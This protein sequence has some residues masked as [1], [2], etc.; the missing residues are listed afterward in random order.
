MATY[1]LTRTEK[2]FLVEESTYATEVVSRPIGT[3]AMPFINLVVKPAQ[4]MLLRK[5]KIGTRTMPRPIA[6][7]NISLEVDIE[8]YLIPSGTR[9]TAPMCHSLLKNILG[10]TPVTINTTVESG[11]T[12]SLVNVVDATGI[13]AGT[14]LFWGTEGRPVLSINTKAV[15]M[16][17]P[18]SSAPGVG[19]TIKGINYPLADSLAS[20]LAVYGY[21][22]NLDQGAL[23]CVFGK[24]AISF[25]DELLHIKASGVGSLETVA[26]GVTSAP[27][28]AFVG[29][30]ISRSF[31]QVY[32]GTTAAQL[33]DLSI[34]VEN[35][36][37]PR[38]YA[39]GTQY[40]SG[41][42]RGDRRI[43]DS[44]K[45]Y[46]TDTYNAFY[47]LAKARTPQGLFVQIGT[48]SGYMVA[49]YMPN[50]I[51]Q[52]PDLD[53]SKEEA[54]LSFASNPAYGAGGDEFYMAIG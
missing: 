9:N 14:I 16:A 33:I 8:S 23:G 12:T 2:L 22:T 45:V 20:S 24:L 31:G 21:K 28:P 19:E 7:G 49:F 13:A 5:D 41:I 34:D 46:L 15:T 30:P 27:S 43:T 50:R 47:A 26:P 35:G 53:K 42:S 32:Y 36:D 17:V 25:V 39:I 3:D 18:F 29:L 51:L 40:I 52:I 1:S 54:Q 48:T 6:G 11:G 44:F 38:D 10:G 37:Q 4:T